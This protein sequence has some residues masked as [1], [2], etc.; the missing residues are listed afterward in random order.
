MSQLSELLK[1]AHYVTGPAPHL[2]RHARKVSR[3]SGKF[4]FVSTAPG[5]QNSQVQYSTPTLFLY[6]YLCFGFGPPHDTTTMAGR[7]VFNQSLKELRFLLCQTSEHS[8][9]TRFGSLFPPPLFFLP[10]APNVRLSFY[11]L[12]FQKGI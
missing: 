9:A 10:S 7:Y 8:A 3:R 5:F 2:K 11:F 4:L 1:F 12:F 6:I